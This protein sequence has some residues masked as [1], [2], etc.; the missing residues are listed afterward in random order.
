MIVSVKLICLPHNTLFSIHHIERWILL[1][2][3][4]P[5][6]DNVDTTPINHRYP[7]YMNMTPIYTNY[8]PWLQGQLN[9]QD[10]ITILHHMIHKST[11]K[12]IN[13]ITWTQIKSLNTQHHQKYH[14]DQLQHATPLKIPHNMK[15]ITRPIRSSI[16]CTMINVDCH[17]K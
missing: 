10:L 1:F 16:T 9:P 13:N 15:N 7:S 3:H 4:I 2:A 12:P 14:Q 17:K 5:L 8:R 11:T 6:S